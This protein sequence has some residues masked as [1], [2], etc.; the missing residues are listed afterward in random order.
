MV[1]TPSESINRSSVPI[2]YHDLATVFSK[3]R[4]LSLPPHRPYDCAIELL[5]GALLCTSHLYNFLR[6]KC[7][8]MEKYIHESLVVGL[9]C[10][11]SSPVGAGFFFLTKNDK[12]LHPCIHYRGLNDK[13][14]IRFLSLIL[15]LNHFIPL[16]CFLH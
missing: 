1:V 13:I 12:T 10:P 16:L 7:E 14:S 4:V 9:I 6:P 3:D 11:S 5:P 8:S 2:K 15:L